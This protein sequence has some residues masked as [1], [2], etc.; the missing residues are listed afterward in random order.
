MAKQDFYDVLGVA[1]GASDSEL[2]AA[3]RKLA[4]KYHPDVNSAG[5]A[6][7]K[8]KQISEA[9]DVL[10]DTKKRGAY[11]QF[12]HA[13]FEQ[14]H[15][16]GSPDFGG[17]QGFGGFDF[18]MDDVFDS[19]FH[20]NGNRKRGQSKGAG[21]KVQGEDLQIEVRLILDDVYK[22]ISKDINIRH[23]EA[24]SICH[25]SGSRDNSGPKTCSTCQGAGQVRQTM[26]TILGNI[27][28]V[29]PCPACH[30]EGHL[31]G[32]PCQSCSGSG[33]S[34]RSK[35]INIKIPAGVDNGSKLR[36]AHEGNIGPNNGPNGDLYVIIRVE[37]HQSFKR[38]HDDLI[39]E[40]PIHFTQ[41]TLGDEVEVPTLDG[42]IKLKIPSGTQSG[43]IFRLKG[44]G[45][46]HLQSS[47][48]GDLL[49]I[50]PIQ[51][52][53]KLTEEQRTLLEYFAVLRNEKINIEHDSLLSKVRK[54]IKKI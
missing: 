10:S 25:G 14:G 21:H 13:A 51:T 16:G 49:V 6:K 22:G 33:R 9:Y 7:D 36:V 47:G 31:I 4:R 45:I 42:K 27:A 39:V 43:T 2:K 32:S 30:G 41:A 23:L 24:C 28:Q 48:T 8:F 15:S 35:T 50:T 37:P 26:Q 46:P 19:F 54:I 34:A 18:N 11:D 5:D 38:D 20:G 40:F 44:K 3:Y 53:T 1:K 12:G 29:V 17:F 52:P